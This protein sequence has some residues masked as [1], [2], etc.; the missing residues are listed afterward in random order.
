MTSLYSYV[1][2]VADG[3]GHPFCSLWPQ[4]HFLSRVGSRYEACHSAV[5]YSGR[6]GVGAEVPACLLSAAVCLHTVGN[7]GGSSRLSL[8][9]AVPEFLWIR[10]A[11][12]LDMILGTK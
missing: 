5:L 9:L 4:T 3:P 11:W 8:S 6:D 2:A 12:S 10:S 7:V 1:G